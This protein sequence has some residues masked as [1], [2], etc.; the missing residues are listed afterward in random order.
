M[1]SQK[2]I[3]AYFDNAASTKIDPKVLESMLPYLI[4]K[5]SNASSLHSWGQ[6]ARKAID[7]ARTSIAELINA[8]PDE[9]IFTGSPTEAMNIA[10]FGASMMQRGVKNKLF[11]T[12]IEHHAGLDPFDH[13][14]PHGFKTTTLPVDKYGLLDLD[15]LKKE[16][17]NNT[18][19]VNVMYVNNEVGTVQPISEIAKIIGSHAILLSDAV[20]AKY[21]E[22]D[23]KKLGVDMMVL[24][25]HKFYGPKGIGILY[26]K[27]GIK[28]IPFIKGGKHEQGLRPGTENVASIV[29]AAKALELLQKT[30]I[31]TIKKIKTMQTKL[32]KGVLSKVKNVRLTGHP[33]LRS[34]DIAS[35][36]VAGVEGEAILLR[37]DAVGIASSS[38]SACTAGDLMP[39]HVLRAMGYKPEECHGSL[40][41]SLG[42]YNTSQEIDYFLQ[43]FPDIID[44]LRQ[45]APK[46]A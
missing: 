32:I 38:G 10:I 30:K 25:P 28:L 19:L 41:L 29:G 23:V 2:K 16:L 42:K 26:V 46:L 24:G 39:S 12:P 45:I 36:L 21:C 7:R 4:D 37:L 31:K 3:K 17:D 35:F 34:P 20:A 9:I 40:R 1:K 18:A 44:N 14:T 11:T 33:H 22:L 8:S 15:F 13:L 27:N 5:Y 6:E 43:F